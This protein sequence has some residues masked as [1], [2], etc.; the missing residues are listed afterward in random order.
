MAKLEELINP[1]TMCGP[2]K[3]FEALRSGPKTTEELVT[4]Y[5]CTKTLRQIQ[6]I[7][8]T[9]N[10][11]NGLRVRAHGLPE[12]P[13]T[14]WEMSIVNTSCPLLK[15]NSA[16]PASSSAPASGPSMGPTFAPSTSAKIG[17]Y[18]P[19]PDYAWMLDA[20]KEGDNLFFH[21]PTGSGKTVSA[22][23]LAKEWK[24]E[25]I[26][27]NFD[28]E[29]VVDNMIGATVVT[30]EDGV[31][32]TDFKD[33]EL[34]RACRLASNGKKILYLADEVQAG[35]PEVLFKFHRVL[36]IDKKTKERS[37]EVNG[38]E[39]KIPG[40]NLTIIGTGNSFKLDESGLYGGSQCM[41]AAF[42]N[43][44]SGGVYFVDYAP[45]EEEI[46]QAAGVN[47]SIAQALVVM[48]RSIRAQAKLQSNPVI[49]STRQL[50]A[51]GQKA[52]KW[53]CR[54]AIELIYLNT[55]LADERKI[56][57]EVIKSIK[58]PK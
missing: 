27:Q 53:G 23:A 58:W 21:G 6:N 12:A 28:G 36:E 22:I 19:V 30:S 46:L 55:L 29:T 43:R 38:E 47:Y 39:I 37:I 11:L 24:A 20:V 41:N 13:G 52:M 7:A 1:Y 3:M 4:S 25:L 8:G 34:A 9:I 16:G 18:I 5:R 33:G 26:R 49:C 45:N 50:I 14:K 54:K 40:G 42:L 51:V 56:T 44:W 17:D 2:H 35:K 57:D 10:S 48:A 32:V 15:G 31:S